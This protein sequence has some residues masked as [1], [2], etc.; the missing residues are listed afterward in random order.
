MISGNDCNLDLI[1]YI[2]TSPEI[3]LER[4]HKRNRIEERKN[5]SLDYLKQIHFFHES[6]LLES[7]SPNESYYRPTSIIVINGDK[8]QE[9]VLESMAKATSSLVNDK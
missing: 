4:I 5:I 6:W 8:S 9:E 3:C 1:F 7:G 2:K